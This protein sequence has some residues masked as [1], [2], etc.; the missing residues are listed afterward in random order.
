MCGRRQP[1]AAQPGSLWHRTCAA[2]G[3]CVQLG[4]WEAHRAASAFQPASGWVLMVH[5]PLLWS[6]CSGS[7]C[8]P[9]FFPAV[10]LG[11]ELWV[12]QPPPLLL[13]PRSSSAPCAASLGPVGQRWAGASAPLSLLALE[14]RSLLR[15]MYLRSAQRSFANEVAQDWNSQEVFI[16]V[17]EM[18]RK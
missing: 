14:I 5:E 6:C 17:N 13:C 18:H 1:G 2:S 7:L 12:F 15:R 10:N 3:C 8:V 4:V 9:F 11:G 16:S